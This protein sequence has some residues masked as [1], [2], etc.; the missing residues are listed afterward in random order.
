MS[1]HTEKEFAEKIRDRL[2]KQLIAVNEQLE[3][4]A[5]VA[6]HDLREPLR[7][8]VC[9]TDLL[10]KEYGNKLDE[11]G[12]RYMDITRQAAKKMESLVSDL[13]EY[14]RV[15]QM[16]ECR[17]ETNVNEVLT[18]AKEALAEAI[19]SAGATVKSTDLPTVQAHPLHL[20]RLFQ[21]LI[22]NAIKYRHKDIPPDISIDAREEKDLWIFSVTDNGI[23]IDAPHL[24]SIFAPFKRLHKDSEYSGTG[25]GLAICKRIV[26][27]F[28]GNIWAE[29]SPNKG[30]TFYFTLPKT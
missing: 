18:E 4:F 1:N 8:I 17:V 9:F 12:R 3:Q 14:G 26:E 6:S 28:G 23:G 22:C 5:Y 7:T 19:N 16:T 20:S 24:E 15:G 11:N 30:S 29:S 21:N 2:V 27:N 13:L 25:I 10:A